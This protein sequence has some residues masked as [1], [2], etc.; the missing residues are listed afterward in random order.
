MFHFPAFPPT[1][2]CVQTAVT[3]HDDCRVSPFGNPR[4]KA[5]VDNSPGPIAASHVLHRFLVPR[6]P[7]CALKNLATD[8]R[9]HC[10]V[11][12]QRTA[13]TPHRHQ[14]PGPLKPEPTA[15]RLGRMTA[16]PAA[17]ETPTAGHHDPTTTAMRPRPSERK[18]DGHSVTP[19]PSGPNSVPDQHPPRDRLPLPLPIRMTATTVLDDHD[20]DPEPSRIVNVPPMSNQRARHAHA[21]DRHWPRTPGEPRSQ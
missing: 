19:V 3:A 12:K 5:L 8:A 2:L 6:H 21:A 7:P 11:L 14:T 17:T 20:H 13:T 15:R 18:P 16:E 10:A 1:A 9:V 4:I